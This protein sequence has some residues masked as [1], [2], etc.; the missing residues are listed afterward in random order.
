MYMPFPEARQ[1][2]TWL[3]R[4]REHAFFKNTL[5]ELAL[6]KDSWSWSVHSNQKVGRKYPKG[7]LNKI[8]RQLEL[9]DSKW[10]IK[11]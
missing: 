6:E 7:I 1:Q 11:I 5:L 4:M 3:W 9:K 8:G 2:K 10:A